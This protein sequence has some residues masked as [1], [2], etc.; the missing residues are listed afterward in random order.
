VDSWC[1]ANSWDDTCV[2]EVATIC[3]L[4]CK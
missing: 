2:N 4:S 1:C 3:K